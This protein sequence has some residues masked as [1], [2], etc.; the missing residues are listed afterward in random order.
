MRFLPLLPASPWATTTA[1]LDAMNAQIAKFQEYAKVFPED[2]E[3]VAAAIAKLKADFAGPVSTV[4]IEA[5]VDARLA[6]QDYANAAADMGVQTYDAVTG[7]FKEMEDALTKFV[8][9]GQLDFKRLTDS[10]IS[11]LARMAVRQNIT[12]RL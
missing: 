11:D 8:I 7:A 5:T 9:K 1:A 10:I 12:G 2:A 4:V 3:K 6:L